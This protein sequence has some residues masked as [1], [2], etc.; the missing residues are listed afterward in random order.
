MSDRAPHQVGGEGKGTESALHR[1]RN[2]SSS[3][4]HQTR[5]ASSQLE[6]SSLNTKPHWSYPRYCISHAA[7]FHFSQP[8]C[9]PSFLVVKWL[10]AF[11]FCFLG[12]MPNNKPLTFEPSDYL[13][14][15][16][17]TVLSISHHGVSSTITQ[18]ET[19]SRA[20]GHPDGQAFAPAHSGQWIER[21][22]KKE[23]W[24][25]M[26]KCLTFLLSFVLWSFL[27]LLCHIR[28][29]FPRGWIKKTKQIFLN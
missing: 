28:R 3:E 21:G 2:C 7:E 13:S 10:T 24:R 14:P 6:S 15:P 11:T 9:S 5:A 22:S 1:L 4:T 18:Q 17:R 26:K 25:K 27:F 20:G 12:T 29:C 8:P 16:P 19:K 23:S